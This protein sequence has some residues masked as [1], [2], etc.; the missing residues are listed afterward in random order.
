[1]QYDEDVTMGKY[2]AAL[3]AARGLP[4]WNLSR[5]GRV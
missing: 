3:D 4:S 1:M 5:F 2:K